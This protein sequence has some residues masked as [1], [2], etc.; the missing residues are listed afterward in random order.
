MGIANNMCF[1]GATMDDEKLLRSMSPK[2]ICSIKESKDFECMSINELQSSLL[3]HEQKL[4]LA[5]KV[6]EQI[7][8]K[9]STHNE[10]SRN[11]GRG[12]GRSGRGHGRGGHGNRD[13][14]NPSHSSKRDDD[15][16]G[17]GRGQYDK[18]KIE[19]YRC[20]NLGLIRVSA[21]RSR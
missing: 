17:K 13:G 18:S 19:C 16:P 5:N 15:S 10:S 20:G 11:R 4:N 6:E 14:S 8:L 9:A 3:V 12:R 21:T 2:W 1:H 7:A